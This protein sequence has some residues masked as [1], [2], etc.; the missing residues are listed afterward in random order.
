MKYD[1]EERTAVFGEKIIEFAKCNK[2]LYVTP[3]FLKY[4]ILSKKT[5]M[6]CVRTYT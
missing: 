3:K 1:L 5:A 2:L 4:L 6:L